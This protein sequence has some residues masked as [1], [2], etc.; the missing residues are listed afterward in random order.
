M[1]ILYIDPI[2]GISGDMM[3]SAFLSAGM[4]F[5][6]IK[7]LLQKVPLQLPAITPVSQMQGVIEGIHLNIEDSHLHLSITEMESVIAGLDVAEKLRQDALGMLEII[8]N[9]ESKIHG[10][11]R[12]ELHLHELSHVDTVIDLLCV[13]K[14]MDYFRIE[15]VYCGPVPCGRGTIKTAHGIIPNPPPVTLE[16]LSGHT[17]VFYDEPL[18]LT[19]P[20]GAT[21]VR[22]YVKDR[23]TVPPFIIEKTGYGVGTYKT[24][25]PDA[26]RIF[27]GVSEGPASDEEIW[28]IECDL[29]DMEMEY[30]GAVADRIRNNGARDV[31]YFP[32]F[33]KKGRP[34]IRLSVTVM[35]DSL[36][37]VVETIYQETTTFGMRLKKEGRRI[38]KREEESIETSYG[39][40]RLKNGY[41]AEGLRIKTHLEFEDIKKIA[42]EKGLPYRMVLDM[43]RTEISTKK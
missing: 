13:A 14:G 40:V 10:I 32:V 21:I 31:L 18:E 5:E 16:I 3:I 27:I 33:M 1:K 7:I 24:T 23:K 12:D 6:E 36:E 17:T 43:I 34:G 11:G 39:P 38:L 37:R 15:K 4:P 8:L 28:V 20:T 25:R 26:L 22:Y 29:D 30:M 19:T 9:A 2:F 41:N 35:Q 42:D